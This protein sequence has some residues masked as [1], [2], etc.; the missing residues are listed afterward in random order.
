M[1][2]DKKKRR[3]GLH[4]WRR[5]YARVIDYYLF[6]LLLGIF[7]PASV[8]EG[9]ISEHEFVSALVIIF[10]WV[11]VESLLLSTW[12]TTPGKFLFNITLQSEGGE[13]ITFM[14]GL[15]R[16]FSVWLKG[17][18]C[19]VLLINIATMTYSYITLQDKGVTSWDKSG[20]FTVIH[21]DIS[22]QRWVAIFLVFAV[23]AALLALP[24]G[25][26]EQNESAL[27]NE[28]PSSLIDDYDI[29]TEKSREEC[30]E[31][32]QKMTEIELTILKAEAEGD[33]YRDEFIET[34]EEYETIFEQFTHYC[35]RFISE[36]T[37]N[38]GTQI[39]VKI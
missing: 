38:D 37:H 28:Y 16:S 34:Q 20:N 6:F 23:F 30:K 11:F 2:S 7:L 35:R 3:V 21:N 13:K 12:G 22:T 9:F 15:K 17:C 10:L 25:E 8:V 33:T 26:Y 36:P 24:S 29:H 1:A 39:K 4:P 27:N 14:R 31:M 32:S 19:G 18:A 5:C